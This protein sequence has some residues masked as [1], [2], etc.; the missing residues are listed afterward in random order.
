[1]AA[2][3]PSMA[4]S[5]SAMR[6]YEVLC[7]DFPRVNAEQAAELETALKNEVEGGTAAIA[8][9]MYPLT[10]PFMK[11]L[12][13]GVRS[14]GL[15]A[16]ELAV[17]AYAAATPADYARIYAIG[18]V[19]RTCALVALLADGKF[20]EAHT[21][22]RC[23]T[24]QAAAAVEVVPEVLVPEVAAGE[25]SDEVWAAEPDDDDDGYA[26]YELPPPECP[27]A[28]ARAPEVAAA[29][30]G[31]SGLCA[32]AVEQQLHTLL[33]CISLAPLAP[34]DLSE[35]RA[36]G[37]SAAL[38]S[39][40]SCACR[41]RDD[42]APRGGLASALVGLLL[43]RLCAE[44]AALPTDLPP[45]LAALPAASRAPFIADVAA[46]APRPGEGAWE[47]IDRAVRDEAPALLRALEG[48]FAT[49][50]SP[51]ERAHASAALLSAVQIGDWY[52]RAASGA[53][54]RAGPLLLDSGVPQAL[55]QLALVRADADDD[56][57]A[58]CW[59]WLLDACARSRDVL[60]YAARVERWALC[61][62][63]CARFNARPAQRAAWR[64]LLLLARRAP[65]RPPAEEDS[66]ALLADAGA[67][68]NR[69]AGISDDERAANGGA[70]A[71]D[72]STTALLAVVE[73]AERLGCAVRTG[74]VDGPLLASGPG[75]DLLDR[76]VRFER[77]GRAQ[78]RAGERS[79]AAGS[80]SSGARG[81]CDEKRRELFERASTAIRALAQSVRAPGKAD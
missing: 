10:E 69:A 66:A 36:L 15:E 17:Q 35:W 43:A 33:S 34:L 23:C 73:L 64:W 48:A 20:G 22:L 53:A 9:T 27:A 29:E 11:G 68:L 6:C 72:A 7:T 39:A 57:L 81:P 31:G 46:A 16:V 40:L 70:G 42:K 77:S 49:T 37:I 67:L 54:A 76:L 28:S 14:H 5:T 61:V 4:A 52:L 47:A 2:V 45:A 51:A 13:Y 25:E 21:A 8:Q 62:R 80:A 79:Q 71:I 3:G 19:R 55:L 32:H 18:V 56:V 78:L 1:M 58:P 59:A 65:V 24:T 75:A 44:P 30:A 12:E 60:A 74:A 41:L 26:A 63:T 38:C 50:P